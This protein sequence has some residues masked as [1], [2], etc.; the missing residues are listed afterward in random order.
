MLVGNDIVDLRDPEAWPDTID[1][2]AIGASTRIDG[3]TAGFSIGSSITVGDY[4]V[5]GFSDVTIGIPVA[6]P[7]VR[8]E[9]GE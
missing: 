4:N 5:D 2:L 7:K 3:P 9:A 6:S 1:L 8:N